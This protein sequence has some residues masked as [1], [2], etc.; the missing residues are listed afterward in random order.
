MLLLLR[1]A[2]RRS[3]LVL[4]A[5]DLRL[6]GH[7]YFIRYKARAARLSCDWRGPKDEILPAF[8]AG[9]WGESRAQLVW[10]CFHRACRDG[11]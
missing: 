1:L 11:M 5:R 10:R 8:T 6:T 3:G 4:P 2:T 7:F 9:S